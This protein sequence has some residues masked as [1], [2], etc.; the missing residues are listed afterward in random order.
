MDPVYIKNITHI[1]HYDVGNMSTISILK[2]KMTR[3][4]YE[5]F[6]MGNVYKYLT[7]C[8]HKGSEMDDLKK[9]QT[10]LTWLIESKNE[11]IDD[12]S[13]VSKK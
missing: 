5:G 8:S 10:Y 1:N 13:L 3:E 6:C 7:R 2:A 12:K 4:Q 11:F 9:A